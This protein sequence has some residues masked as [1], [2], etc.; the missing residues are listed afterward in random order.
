MSV[1]PIVLIAPQIAGG[2]SLYDNIL[3]PVSRT[4]NMKSI[5]EFVNQF[6]NSRGR[7]T[8]LHVIVSSAMTVSPG[9]WRQ[10]LNAIS[11]TH[12]LTTTSGIDTSGALF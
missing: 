11:T 1:Q 12:M 7:I 5:L 4:T 3:I 10:A 2:P 6:L 8:F 9:E